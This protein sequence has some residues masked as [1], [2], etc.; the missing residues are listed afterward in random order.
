MN[1]VA[2]L[3]EKV[4]LDI[5]GPFHFMMPGNQIKGFESIVWD[6]ALTSINYET[7]NNLTDCS[8]SHL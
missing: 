4:V 7:F 5:V 8:K 3:W 1:G 2:I 6:P